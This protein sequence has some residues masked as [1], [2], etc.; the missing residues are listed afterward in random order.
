M[1]NVDRKPRL[2]RHDFSVSVYLLYVQASLA[3]GV[4]STPWYSAVS[5][6]SD[7]FSGTWYFIY[8]LVFCA[9][10][11]QRPLLWHVV[12]HRHRGILRNRMSATV[13]PGLAG[14]ISVFQFIFC[15]SRLLWH[16]VFYLHRGILRN[17]MPATVSPG[18]AGTISVFQF[19]FCKSRLLW[20]AIF[21]LHRKARVSWSGNGMPAFVSRGGKVSRVECG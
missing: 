7:C 21:D 12:F 10:G 3:R 11:C 2:G 8:T 17:R 19:I 13:S 14:M 5:C 1:A 6:V 16:V 9:I 20:Q 18:L 4:S 15:K